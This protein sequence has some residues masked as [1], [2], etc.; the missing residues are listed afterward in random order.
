MCLQTVADGAQLEEN[1]ETLRGPAEES[2]AH[3]A[4]DGK[5][6]VVIHVAVSPMLPGALRG[7]CI[8]LDIHQ[9]L[10]EIIGVSPFTAFYSI[11]QG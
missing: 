5:Q 6:M 11:S 2:Q 1:D 8:D 3:V 7:V 4:H 10:G 9:S